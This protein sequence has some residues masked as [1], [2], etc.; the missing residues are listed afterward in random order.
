MKIFLKLKQND[1]R[2][3]EYFE[4]IKFIKHYTLLELK[5]NIVK[6][7]IDDLNNKIIKKIV[8]IN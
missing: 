6:K 8:N 2:L 1:R 3:Q 7:L 5:Y 4:K